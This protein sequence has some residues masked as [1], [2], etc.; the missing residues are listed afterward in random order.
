MILGIDVGVTGA[1][2]VFEDDGTPIEVFDLPVMAN[3]K[4]AARVKSQVNAGALARRLRVFGAPDVAYVEAVAA[5]PG[6]GVSSMFS[7][8]HSLGTVCAVL[9]TLSIPFLLVQPQ[10]W[11]TQFGLRKA[12]KD[13]SRTLAIRLCPTMDLSLKKHH[14]RAEAL[15]IAAYGAA[16][17]CHKEAI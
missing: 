9:A 6:Q 4:R 16:R 14:N 5:R 11:K 12:D 10:A 3:G 13:A 7:L 2:A 15:L 17:S 8:G 1:V